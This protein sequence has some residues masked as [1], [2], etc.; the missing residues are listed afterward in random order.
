MSTPPNKLPQ[1]FSEWEKETITMGLRDQTVHGAKLVSASKIGYE[2]FILFQ[3]LWIRYR[4]TDNLHSLLPGIEKW[5]KKADTMLKS[6][7]SWDAYCRGFDGRNLNEG[8]FAIARYYQLEVVKTEDKAEPEDLVTPIAHRTR[9]HATMDQ[10]ITK[11]HLQTP[12]KSTGDVEM[13]DVEEFDSDEDEIDIDE[14]PEIPSSSPF[15]PVTPVSKEL[16]NVLYPPSLDEQIVNCALVIFL[17][18]LTVHFNIA[19]NWTL[20]RKAFKAVFGDASFEARTDGYLNHAG[21]PKVILEV[22][23][24]SRYAKESLIQMQESAQMVAWIKSDTDKEHHGG[25]LYEPLLFA[26]HSL[27]YQLFVANSNTAVYIS[28]KTAMKFT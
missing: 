8:T 27:V 26:L 1:K 5:I 20:H 25:R 17:N 12:T 3:I 15:R 21:Q 24:A 19:S 9:A 28:P 13:M 18:A 23:P 7:Q 22:K 11:S 6:Y 10:R 2:V 4:S 14:T 16:A